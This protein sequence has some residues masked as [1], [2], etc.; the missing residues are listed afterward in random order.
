[1]PALAL[2]THARSVAG[3]V[4]VFWLGIFACCSAC[5]GSGDRRAT[6]PA[7]A[8]D[9]REKPWSILEL[10]PAVAGSSGESNASERLDLSRLVPSAMDT[11]WDNPYFGFN[12]HIAKDD[13]IVIYGTRWDDGPVDL[14]GVRACIDRHLLYVDSNPLGVL[15]TSEIPP[16]DSKS[17]RTL[18]PVLDRPF[19]RVFYHGQD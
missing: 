19:V 9:S 18:M 8:S 10:P 1:M 16:T 17:L 3:P 12:V 14:A 15:V 2:F 11:E 7:V 6:A 5:V 13:S 4:S